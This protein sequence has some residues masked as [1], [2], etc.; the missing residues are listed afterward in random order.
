MRNKKFY[1]K[2]VDAGLKAFSSPRLV[3]AQAAFM[4]A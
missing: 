4:G 2:L 1:C 3:S